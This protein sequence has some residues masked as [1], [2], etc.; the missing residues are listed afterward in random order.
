MQRGPKPS[1][2]LEGGLRQQDAPSSLTLEASRSFSRALT[3]RVIELSARR[4][5]TEQL[6]WLVTAGWLL[7][8][9]P[10]SDTVWS[11]EGVVSDAWDGSAADRPESLSIATLR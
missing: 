2:Q 3:P 1:L 5:E 8:A 9:K 6:G 4:H 11:K 7:A 10:I